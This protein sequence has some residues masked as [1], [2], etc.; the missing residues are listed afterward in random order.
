VKK[1]IT[2]LKLNLAN[3]GKRQKLDE[4]AAEHQRVVQASAKTRLF[5]VI[6]ASRRMPNVVV[7]EP[8]G[9]LTF[10]LRQA[11]SKPEYCIIR[12]LHNTH[13]DPC[14]NPFR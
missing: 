7:I 4:L 3:P 12:S 13:L 11:Y 14:L 10:D 2:Q 8:S 1:A 9:T 5:C 6:F